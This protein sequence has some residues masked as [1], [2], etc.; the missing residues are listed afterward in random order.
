MFALAPWA[1][2]GAFPPDLVG[3]LRELVEIDPAATVTSFDAVDL[4]TVELI[5]SGWGCPR[6]DAA[7]LDRAPKLQ[8][9]IHTAGTVKK[10]LD[11]VVFERGVTVSS[12]A[13]ANAVPVAEYTIAALVLAAKQA[14]ARAR[15]SPGRPRADS[16]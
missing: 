6:L 5:V 1:R 16:G 14:F 8:T 3:R 7:V 13:L 15:S 12:A 11:P 10:L 4:S 2:D 9:Y